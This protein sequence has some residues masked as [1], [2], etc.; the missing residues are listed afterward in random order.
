[1]RAL[2]LLSLIGCGALPRS[3]PELDLN[4]LVRIEHRPDGAV[5]LEALGP[6][7]DLRLGP[8]GVSHAVRPLYQHRAGA[9]GSVT[10]WLAPLG[11]TVR[12]PE[13][14]HSRLWPLV[15][16]AE[17]REGPDG[18][19]WDAVLFPLVFAGS[20]A[21]PDD[22]Y[23]A[24]F[25]LAGRIRGLF[26]LE[27][28]DFLLWPLFMRTRMDVTEPSTSWTVLLLGGWTSGGP[29]DG[30]WR[31]LPF[32]RRRL[33]RNAEG[34][35]VTDQRSVLWPLFTWGDDRLDEDAPSERVAF[36]PFF[37]SE[38]SADW[39]RLTVLWPFF[40]YNRSLR[41]DD[42]LIDAPWP[43]LR[44]SRDGAHEVFR[45]FPLYSRREHPDLLS[46]A[47]L[48]PFVWARDAVERE[49]TAEGGSARVHRS[50]RWAIPFWYRGTRRVE[51]REGESER[52]QAWPLVHGEAHADGRADHGVPSLLPARH[53]D[54][55]SPFEQLFGFLWNGWRRRS[56]GVTSEHRLLFETIL[57]REGP[58]GLRVS[59]PFVYARRP[60]AGGLAR[61][62]WLWGLVTARTDAR[63]LSRLTLCGWDAWAR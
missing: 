42:H 37:A 15:W 7:V 39:R 57:V 2:L 55:L 62:Q 45:L 17:R 20:G 13:R 48:I 49:R 19:E 24:V 9:Q 12:R 60:E 28:F 26:G 38:T 36:W 56:D 52:W 3:L 34:E 10:D 16:S 8:E 50:D 41:G 6:L 1:M 27:S 29:R 51:G 46:R 43:I 32:Y 54:V 21:G 44:S 23:L 25:P 61:H 18:P 63:G 59:T 22:T 30:S 33:R 5:E 11:R 14:T 53:L 4:P 40:R 58:E 31:L 35:L 47:W